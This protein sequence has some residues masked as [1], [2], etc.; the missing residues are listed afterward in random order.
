MKNRIELVMESGKIPDGSRK[1]HKGFAE[2][3]FSIKKQDHQSIVQVMFL[4]IFFFLL[5]F[6]PVGSLETFVVFIFSQILIDGRD[7]SA[8][9]NDGSRLPTLVYMSRE[10]RPKWPHH[11]KAGALNAVVSLLSFCI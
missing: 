6:F 11:F 9:D 3:N 10:K 4:D 5:L 7:T 1:Q 2:W 8:V